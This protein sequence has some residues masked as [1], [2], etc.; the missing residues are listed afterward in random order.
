MRKLG[1]TPSLERTIV[2]KGFFLIFFIIIIIFCL[3]LFLFLFFY[4]RSLENKN[5]YRT[6]QG[7]YDM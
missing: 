2:G 1:K 4:V 3:F 7:V 6:M 5:K